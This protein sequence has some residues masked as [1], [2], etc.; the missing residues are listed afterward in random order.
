M[1][2]ELIITEKPK[3]AAR[4]AAALSDSKPSVKKSGAVSHYVVKHNGKQI[5]VAPAVGHIFG[6]TEKAS[7]WKYPVF[8][9]EWKP[10]FE[11]DKKASYTKG[12][13]KQLVSLAKNATEFT[14][15]CDYDV[16]GELIGYNVV[17]FI[18]KAKDAGR[19]KFSTLTST[20]I[21]AAYKEKAKHINMPQAIAGETRHILDWYYGINVSRALTTALKLSGTFRIL[22]S[23]RVQGPALKIIVDRELEIQAF[24]PKAFWRLKY[25]GKLKTE[26]IEGYHKEDKFW[27]KAKAESVFKKCK[28]KPGKVTLFEKTKKLQ[29]APYPFDLT[30]LQIEAHRWFGMT[31]KETL[32][33]AQ[34]LYLGGYISYPRTSSQKLLPQL[35]FKKLI[36]ALKKNPEYKPLAEKVLG[37]KKLWP[38]NG[39]KED[40]AHPAIYPTGII[41]KGLKGKAPK[42]YDLIVKRFLACF[43]E[44]AER[45]HIKLEFSVEKEPFVASG[46]LTTVPG[47]HELY[48]PYV[49]LNEQQMPK[50]AQGDEVVYKRLELLSDET[51]PPK[52]YS[53]ASLVK[54]LSDKNLGTKATR[55]TIVDTL[56]KRGYA[57]GRQIEATKLG[58]SIIQIL[59]KEVPDV[60]DEELTKSFE[61]E[62][63]GIREGKL[64]EQKV[65][66]HA[67]K[68]L[69]KALMDFK[70]REKQIGMELAEANKEARIDAALGICPK[71]KK[72]H[73]VIRHSRKGKRFIACD[74]YPDCETTFPL[75]QIG[76]VYK[77]GLVCEKCNHPIIKIFN[78]GLKRTVMM[79][80]N[81]E[82]ETNKSEHEGMLCPECKK[83]KL[84][85]RTSKYGRFLAC[86]RYPDCK[87]TERIIP[88]MNTL[89]KE[90]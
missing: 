11:I 40:P 6:V 43:G 36:S 27:D 46:A 12:Y 57:V 24:K 42:V 30:T 55:A 74:R 44:P 23:G 56:F 83:G 80:I 16:E 69:S 85:V 50:A 54:V 70:Q 33:D 65:L 17:R 49:K 29:Y 20:D 10:I 28:G 19:M 73:L 18:C 3:Q 53:Q 52:R 48:A 84:V 87:Y 58:I 81:P 72:G 37:L 88:K 68:V 4:I 15:S 64:E 26:S 66:E 2:Y 5:V 77:T 41:P 31:P 38:N 71:C 89:N 34:S 32:A 51:K 39:K 61:E 78:P 75:A 76:K 22:S 21:L 7:G 35:G 13:Y 90:G 8:D 79:C 60:I 82:C 62:M 25:S 59:S 1:G 14:V 67:K 45:E 63:D 9:T 86:D 47:W